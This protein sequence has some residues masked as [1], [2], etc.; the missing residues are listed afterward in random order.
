MSNYKCSSP[1]GEKVVDMLTTP[2]TSTTSYTTTYGE[3]ATD[4]ALVKALV[5]NRESRRKD[6]EKYQNDKKR[7]REIK[8]EDSLLRG[9]RVVPF[10][11]THPTTEKPLTHT[12]QD[13]IVYL[14]SCLKNGVWSM[15]VMPYYAG[16]TCVERGDYVGTIP[17]ALLHLVAWPTMYV[18]SGVSGLIN[19]VCRSV[20]DSMTSVTGHKKRWAHESAI[21]SAL[22]EANMVRVAA[23]WTEGSERK[24]IEEHQQIHRCK[25]ARIERFE[26]MKAAV[27]EVLSERE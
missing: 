17:V 23:S 6:E 16:A 13:G 19:G 15:V 5:K 1:K 26:D 12:T 14:Y 4:P 18:V 3:T 21:Q 7:K 25:R 22:H 11:W 2:E 20:F 9:G 24:I 27:K 8:K 10:V